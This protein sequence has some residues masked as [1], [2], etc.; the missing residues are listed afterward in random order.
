MNKK[1]T[2]IILALACIGF[3]TFVALRYQNK[4][5]TKINA[6]YP[7]QERQGTTKW[8]SDW[9]VTNKRASDLIQLVRYNPEDIKSALALATLYIQESRITG[10]AMYYDVAAMKYIDGVL[11]KEPEN[12]EALTLKSLVYLSQHHFADGLVTAEKAKKA[13]PY[14]AFAYGLLVD[15]HVEMGNYKGAIDN[16]DQMVSLRPDIRSYS[17]IAY[18][19]EI[20]GD[21]EG[22]IEAM[23]K[24]VEAGA[25]GDEPTSWARI[26]LGRL[27]ENTGDLKSAEMHYTI[28]LDQRPGYPYAIAGLGHVAIANRD[29][30]KAI[31]LYET[32]DSSLMDFSFKEQLASLYAFRGD[33]KKSEQIMKSVID[34]M[35]KDAQ[36]GVEDETIGHYADRELAYAY[37]QVQEYEKALTHALAEYNRRPENIDVNETVAWVYYKKGEYT[38]AIPYINAALKTNCKNPVLRLRA[39]LILAENQPAKA[40]AYLSEALALNPNIDLELKAQALKVFKSL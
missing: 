22:A 10:N 7:L 23:K 29:Y 19:R 20:H 12:F 37:L 35:N 33:K 32:A 11:E 16:A 26:Q 38:K 14:N 31:S 13:G 28:A 36:K 8:S 6:F 27:F 3:I 17:R 30:A 39:G 40:K 4:L 18:L 9:A 2:Y 24:A 15:A 21:N 1:Y 5:N 34:G 25:P